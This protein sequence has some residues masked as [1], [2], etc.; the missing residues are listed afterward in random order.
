MTKVTFTWEA[1]DESLLEDRRGVLPEFPADVFP[2]HLSGWLDRASRGAGTLVDHIAVPMLGVTSS[3]IGKARRIRASTSWI[4]PATL[5]TCIVGES[6]TRK[7]PGFNAIRRTLDQIEADNQPQ[8]REAHISHEARKEKVKAELHQWRKRCEKAVAEKKEPPPMPMEAVDPGDFIWPSIYVSDSTIAR[9][10]RLCIVRPRGM[11]Q[12]RDELAG[13]MA[14]IKQ[15][16][17]GRAFYLESWDGGKFVVERV[18]D[19]RALVVPNL[20]VGVVGGFQPDKLS[21]AFKGDQ[22]GL[23]ARFLY[24]W[25]GTPEYA[26]LTDVIEEVDPEFKSLM[27][28]FIRLPAEDSSG[29]FEARIVPLSAEARTEFEGY[30]IFVDRTKRGLEGRE[31]EWLSKSETHALRLAGTLA[32]LS[33][34]GLGSLKGMAGI[35]ALMEPN[36]VDRRSMTDAAMLMREYFWPHARAAL[37]LIGQTE[38]HA[39]ARRTLRWIRTR[40]LPKVSIQDV[41]RDCLSFALDAGRTRQLFDHLVEAGW[42]RG[43]EVVETGGRPRER[44]EVN[45]LLAVT[46]QSAQ[47]PLSAISAVSARSPRRKP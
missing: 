4:E 37:R 10:A 34:A 16:A 11:L 23:Y 19:K 40:E 24:G 44:W 12:I 27:T 17:G 35:T 5:W 8:H 45:P 30:R 47:R 25:P 6:G 46:A 38:R 22:D 14:S 21:S 18:D 42:L 36:E 20:L 7:T 15:Q 13:L 2:P 3:L 9:L 26:S 28:K 32:Y 1:P 31:A 41:R 33:W 43:P 29:E 39:H